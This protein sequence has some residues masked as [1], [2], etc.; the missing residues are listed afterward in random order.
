MRVQVHLS[1]LDPIGGSK[2]ADY[3]HLFRAAADAMFEKKRYETAM[4]FYR[5]LKPHGVDVDCEMLTAMGRCLAMLGDD[6]GASAYYEE[7]LELDRTD[8]DCRMELA[9]IYER[10]DLSAKAYALVSEVMNI[11]KNNRDDNAPRRRRYIKKALMK[12]KAVQSF[13][14]PDFNSAAPNTRR[15]GKGRKERGPKIPG[16]PKTRRSRKGDADYEAII[17]EARALQH[18]YKITTENFSGMRQGD[19]DCTRAWVGAATT[20]TNDFRMF[21]DFYPWESY[22]KFLGYSADTLVQVQTPLD[23]E[24]ESMA[25]RLAKGV[26]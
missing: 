14:R 1:H 6:I 11:H 13:L 22:R 8:I 9:K 26:F 12:D 24:I 7:A 10:Q 21:R 15:R 18:Q 16:A 3:H 5:A 17:F 20:L 23:R 19:M 2:I 4:V 25:E